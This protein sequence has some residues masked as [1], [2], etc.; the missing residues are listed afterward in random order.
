MQV[1]ELKVLCR[2]DSLGCIRNTEIRESHPQNLRLELCLE[3][4]LAAPPTTAKARGCSIGRDSGQC[5]PSHSFPLVGT[6][7]TRLGNTPQMG[8]AKMGKTSSRLPHV[9]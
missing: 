1:L 6:P 3:I 9:R 4:V 8:E 5:F 2:G 7:M